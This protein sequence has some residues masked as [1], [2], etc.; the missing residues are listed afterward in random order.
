MSTLSPSE[1]RRL[2]ATGLSLRTIARTAGVSLATVQRA[3]ATAP[4]V[5]DAKPT[6]AAVTPPRRQQGPYA[7]D[8]ERIRAARDEQLRGVFQLP[9][10]LAEA[11]RTDDA[12]FTAYQARVATQSA[13]VL[14]WIAADT[15]AGE[16]ATAQARVLVRAPQHV[17]E[18]LLGTMANHGIAVGYVQ[19]ETLDG[20]AAVACTLTEWPL[21][22][23]RY[24]AN[25][26]TLETAVQD[27]ISRVQIRHGDGHWV[28]FRKFGIAPWTQDAAILPCA[29]L[30]AAHSQ[31]ISDWAGASNSHGQPKVVGTLPEGVPLGSDD[32]DGAMSSEAAS[33]LAT[34][35]DLVCGDA[36][37][38]VVP[39]GSET[40]MLY[41]GSTAWQVFNELI[42]NRESAAARVYLGTDA[43]LG[44]RGGAPGVDV[45][46]LF[47]IATTRIQGDLEA[48]ERGFR[49][50]LIEPWCVMHGVS[51]ADAP[52]L[53][54]ALPDID[55]DKRAEQ[56]AAAIDRLGLSVAA[57]KGAGLQVTQA[58]IDALAQTLGVS[59]PTQ[60]APVV[61]APAPEPAQ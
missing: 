12:L 3:L 24:N 4:R 18:S 2:R 14:D 34:L 7:W 42:T 20:G 10:R 31:G 57:M 43:I 49:E 26:N 22:H 50:G 23:V 52:K 56:E 38:G 48:L 17:R 44:S 27:G 11:M 28:V 25:D 53:I 1:A 51:L 29:M 9:V 21:E 59:V 15:P 19:H 6:R 58:T 16:S 5:R 41:N 47:G 45:A 60:L 37:A 55:A 39:A 30:W 33:Y 13:I 54:Y 36:G 46:A 35:T 8:L 61:T 40:V 32:E